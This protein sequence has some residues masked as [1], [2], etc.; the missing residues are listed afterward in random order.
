MTPS[1]SKLF[2]NINLSHIDPN[3]S[4]AQILRDIA[5]ELKEEKFYL[6]H[7]NDA[8][9]S[10]QVV[11][12][13]IPSPYRLLPGEDFPAQVGAVALE[14]VREWQYWCGE[15]GLFPFCRTVS[16]LGCCSGCM[17]VHYT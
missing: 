8:E 17:P 2:V 13:E 5:H 6:T 16:G 14:I 1:P 11:S 9:I 4:P 15:G 3:I 12:I 10:P 7:F